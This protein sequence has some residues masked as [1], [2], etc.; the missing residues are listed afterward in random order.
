VRRGLGWLL[1][2]GDD[3]SAGALFS[4]A[5]FGHTGFTGTSLWI[6]PARRLVVACLSNRVYRGRHFTGILAFRRALHDA[7]AREVDHA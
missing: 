5:S 7:I 6:D 1:K 3:S 2:G 4:P